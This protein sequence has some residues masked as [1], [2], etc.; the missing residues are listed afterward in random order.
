LKRPCFISAAAL[1]V[2]TT[3]SFS[4]CQETGL[5]SRVAKNYSGDVSLSASFDV[6]ILWKIREKEETKHGKII[7]A[8]GDRFRIELGDSRWVCDGTTL[9]QYD[10]TAGQVIIR[11]LSS[12]DQSQ[13]PSR[14]LSKYLTRYSFKE[15]GTK[16]TSTVFAWTVDTAA[17]QNKGEA[18]RITFTVHNK[19]AVVQELVVV[20]KS[21]NESSYTFHATTFGKQQSSAFSFGI[22]KGARV[23][24]ERQ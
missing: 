12:C 19:N 22:P 6:K 23:L 17:T 16:G 8:P 15:Q 4:I 21:G 9:W 1:F 20:D 13:L 24:D 2:C 3:V 14:M 11:R 18:Q 10:K 7:C 5:L